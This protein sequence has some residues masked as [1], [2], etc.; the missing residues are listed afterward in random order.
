MLVSIELSFTQ[1]GVPVVNGPGVLFLLSHTNLT[2][3]DKD[4]R[5]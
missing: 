5:C 4:S 2:R 3:N 1:K